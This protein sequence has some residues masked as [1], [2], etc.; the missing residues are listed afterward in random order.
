MSLSN[1][2]LPKSILVLRSYNFSAFIH[3]LLAGVTV[4]M[5]ALPLAMAFGIA[6]GVT[7][8]AGL[9]T[10]IVAGF[11]ISALGGS[12]TQIGGPTGAFVV[13]VAGI[14]GKFGLPGLAM[15]TFMAG[16]LLVGMGLTG[17]GAAVRF[18]PRMVIIGFT[19][20]IAILIASTQIK[21][22]FG[23]RI[24]ATPSEFLPRMR[25]IAA[26]F[27]SF[28]PAAVA[29]GAVTIAVLVLMPRLWRRVPASIVA[30]AVCTLAAWLLR[31]PVE[32]IGSRFG[33]IPRGLP[34]IALP[35]FHAEHVLPLLAPAFTVAMLAALESMLS[36]VVADEMTGDR[37]N[38]NVE[39]VA[40]GVANIVSPLFG[41]IP[42]TGAIAR[43]ATNIRAGARS[44]V[45]GIVHALTLLG[46]LLVAAPLAGYIPLAT[47]AGVLFVVAYNMGHWNEIG[48]IL[49]L[50]FAAISV[51]M[52]T[53]ALTVFADLTV[54]VGVG[55]TLAAL[56]YIYRVAETTT[57]GPVTEDYI[58]DGLP[59]S[60]QGRILPSY[61][62]L[63]R[64]HGPFLFGTT[65]KLVD[66]T[67]NLE[68]L[69]PIVVLRL[70]NM[71][72][73]DASGIHAIESFA[74]RLRR[75]GRTLLLC[76]AMEQPSRL[77]AQSRFLDLIGRENVL[78][79]IQAA[80]DRARELHDS[81]VAA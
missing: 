53:F 36:A 27:G 9:Y 68:A 49:R 70:R 16:I 23:L 74:Q 63:L 13:I 10:A 31:L 44:P 20:G 38:S 80:L 65:E 57:V 67:A 19:N 29:L 48:A 64:I 59:H 60:L 5:V 69:A 15:V 35:D 78:P 22:F 46:I 8:Q 47:L 26:H 6:S 14:L 77:L 24:G 30:V 79:N 21:D 75:S 73:I 11:L 33:G 25:M 61:I 58:R 32:T 54:A 17:L 66:A 41:G 81:T 7:P 62:S 37:H 39:L 42:A 1:P 12:R 40:Q 71:T 76:G 28:N 4:G 3:D 2:Q 72:A 45:A 34:A 55:L 52:A 51:W 43:T 18:I 50:D 56:L